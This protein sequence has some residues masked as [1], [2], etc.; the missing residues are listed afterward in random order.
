MTQYLKKGLLSCWPRR[1]SRICNFLRPPDNSFPIRF[2]YSSEDP[3]P[4][5]TQSVWI[6]QDERFLLHGGKMDR[7]RVV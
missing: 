7:L 4:Q 1:F 6:P 5:T 2:T 3:F